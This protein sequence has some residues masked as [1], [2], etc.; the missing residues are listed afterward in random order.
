MYW[1]SMWASSINF[2]KLLLKD[3]FFKTFFESF[4]LHFLSSNF[5]FV[6]KHFDKNQPNV[7]EFWRDWTQKIEVNNFKKIR[8]YLYENSSNIYVGKVH[9]LIFN[10]WCIMLISAY[11]PIKNFVENTN[12][13]NY[14][15]NTDD[16]FY[17][18]NYSQNLFFLKKNLKTFINFKKFSFDYF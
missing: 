4:F 7:R 14:H 17:I 9:I 6:S 13:K 18:S 8:E 12:T 16:S 10:G 11:N 3:F 2:N 1:N 5:F 15:Q